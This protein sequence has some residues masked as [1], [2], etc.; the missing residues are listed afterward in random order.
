MVSPLISLI[1][2]Q[3]RY[4]NELVPGSAAM[5]SAGM[6]KRETSEVYRRMRGDDTDGTDGGG[7]G[8]GG[9]SGGGEGGRDG[10]GGKGSGSPRLVMVLV[11]PEKV[12]CSFCVSVRLSVCLCVY[13]CVCPSI[14]P[15]VGVLGF[16]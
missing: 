2:D 15:S 8:S 10:K 1:E 7:S 6:D 12:C 5:L 4:L 11:T 16:D 3:T 9:G 14:C 13:L